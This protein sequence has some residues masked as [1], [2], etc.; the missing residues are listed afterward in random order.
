M[1]HHVCRYSG[2]LQVY[3]RFRAYIW[4]GRILKNIHLGTFDRKEQAAEAVDQARFYLWV[5]H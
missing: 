5:I 4:V 2:V 1:F 3:K